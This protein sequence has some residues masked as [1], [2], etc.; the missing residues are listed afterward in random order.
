MNEKPS[1]QRYGLLSQLFHWSVVALMI[2]LVV[3]DKLRAGALKDTPER[4]EWLNLHMSLGILLFLIVIARI[5]WTRLSPQPVPLP[6]AQWT[7][8]TA[9]LTHGLL[10]LATLLVPIFGYLRAAS[11][12][13]MSDFFGI[14]I[15]SVTGELPWLNDAMHIFHGEPMEV[16]FY[17]VIGLHVAAAFWHQYYKRDG[18][19]AR[20]LPWGVVERTV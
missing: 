11:K 19:I 9:K 16:F 7:L 14:Q 6:G 8:I 5:V 20:M 17:V 2:G 10:N 12:P 13:R 3:T 1:L 18:A 4:L 15:P